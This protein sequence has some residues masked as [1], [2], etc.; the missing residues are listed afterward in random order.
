MNLRNV[1]NYTIRTIKAVVL[2]IKT[3]IKNNDLNQNQ[4]LFAPNKKKLSTVNLLQFSFTFYIH[5]I[6][7]M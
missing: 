3:K 4:K 6:Q 5:T 7:Y 1:I 2:L